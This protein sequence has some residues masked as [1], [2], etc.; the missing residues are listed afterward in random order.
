MDYHSHHWRCGHA[1]GNIEDYI[2][3]AIDRGLAEIGIA[4]HFPYGPTSPNPDFEALPRKERGMAI[5]EFPEYIE[6]IKELRGKYRGVIQVRISTEMAFAAPGPLLD[7]QM[8]VLGPFMADLDYLLCGLHW[9]RIDDEIVG[10]H[11][12]NAPKALQTHG[13]DRIHSAYI[14][15]MTAMVETGCFDIVTHLDNHKLLWLPNEPVY[16]DAH[17]QSMLTL[18]DSIKANGVAVE[19]NTHATRKG[20]LSQFPSDGIVRAMIERSIPLVLSSDAHRPGDI[21]H[22]FDDFI[23]KARKWGLTH[24][25]SYEKRKQRLVPMVD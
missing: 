10:L 16:S 21:G 1:R 8:E 24:L 25:C 9:I 7:R 14:E 12:D 18:L 17:W 6:E 3:A 22:G 15:K 4:D 13:E 23:R 20:C 11:V 5:A 19:I 2:K